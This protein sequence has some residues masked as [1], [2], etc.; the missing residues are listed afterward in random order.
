MLLSLAEPLVV[1]AAQLEPAAE[2]GSERASLAPKVLE[3]FLSKLLPQLVGAHLRLSGM[4]QK[5]LVLLVKTLER[6]K[7]NAAVRLNRLVG[8][9]LCCT[10]CGAEQGSSFPS[11]VG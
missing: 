9:V 3:N 6:V 1:E 11:N 4:H 7:A 8:E 5:F 2:T 10:G